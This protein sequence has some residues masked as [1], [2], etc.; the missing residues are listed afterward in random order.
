MTGQVKTGAE[1]M[2]RKSTA[3]HDEMGKLREISA[4]VTEKVVEMRKANADIAAFLDKVKS[5]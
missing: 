3:I 2:T 1:A 5:R 4:G